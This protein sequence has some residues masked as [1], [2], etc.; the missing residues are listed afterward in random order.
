MK[1]KWTLKDKIILGYIISLP[2]VLFA[3]TF[4]DNILVTACFVVYI[5]SG[6]IYANSKE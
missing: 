6:M 4:F 2:F 5:A 1:T 3:A